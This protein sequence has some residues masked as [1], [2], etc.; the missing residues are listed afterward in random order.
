MFDF[1]A[2]GVISHVSIL[3]H[4][5][6][7]ATVVHPVHQ[8]ILGV[9]FASLD[10]DEVRPAA[11]SVWVERLDL[12]MDHWLTV[13]V[14]V[15]FIPVE[16]NRLLGRHPKKVEVPWYRTARIENFP[17]PLVSGC[18]APIFVSPPT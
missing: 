11:V 1:H 13:V 6:P 12:D 16:G 8:S 4:R 2:H 17:M 14:Y 18:F 7:V 3:P 10:Y 5:E 15:L 9:R